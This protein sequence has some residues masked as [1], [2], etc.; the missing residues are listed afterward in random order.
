M[1]LPLVALACI[2]ALAPA[3]PACTT[4][5][6]S[7]KATRDGRPI[8]WKNRD[9]PD[10]HNQIVRGEGGRFTYV[11]VAN[12]GD[13]GGL[14]I[15]SGVNAAG[16]AIMNNVSYNLDT[17]A[18]DSTQEG[19]FMKLALQ[20]CATVEEFQAL[21]AGTD[22]GGRLVAANF[23]V[24]DA[25]GGAAYFET[26]ERGFHRFDAAAAPGGFLVRTNFSFSG[27]KG[28]GAGYLREARARE[29]VGGLQASGR[30][31]VEN[32]LA[33][34]A[35]DAS[36]P[37]IGSF[38]A[39][40]RKG[41]AYTGDSINRNSTAN[42][43]MVQ[44][45]APGESAG[46]STAWVVLGQPVTGVAVPLWVEVGAV[47]AELD[48]R[49]GMPA[50]HTAFD[51]VRLYVYPDHEDDRIKYLDAARLYDPATG[52]LKPFMALERQN[53]EDVRKAL[54]AAHP[55][56]KALQAEVA[57]RTLDKVEALLLDRRVPP[58]R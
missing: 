13:H 32:L 46:R 52:L 7:G 19:T 15:W 14:Q 26:D 53:F 36:N 5:I 34:A 51:R 24:I 45:V 33:E 47:P 25:Q 10:L 55:D 21:L 41:F 4:G 38:P 50:L 48:G 22:G 43:F 29:L 27:R 28:A 57:K 42:A 54:E 17:K 20:T 16:F 18:D 23:G 56:L 31:T 49:H 44:G 58:A 2:L 12:A 3:A 37:H 6:I 1:R 9:T 8:L 11:G 39:D 35:R 30:L 40:T